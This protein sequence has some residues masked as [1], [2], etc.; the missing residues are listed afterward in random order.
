[1]TTTILV[2]SQT[3]E[4]EK[5][6]RRQRLATGMAGGNAVRNLSAEAQLLDIEQTL[7]SMIETGEKLFATSFH[8]TF[9]E[10]DENSLFL[11]ELADAERIGAGCRWFEETVGAY[12]V[13][14]GIL[15]FA[16][17]FLV[18][19][20]RVLSSVLSDLLPVYGIGAGHSNAEVLFETPYQSAIGF[21]L[22]EKSPSGNGL[23]IGSTGTGKS[24]LACGLILGMLAQNPN[25]ETKVGGAA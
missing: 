1:L 9:F 2:L 6:S 11:S 16:P 22:F 8:L 23:L 14:F 4:K 18:R 12:P 13:F 20:K 15:P 24:T 25:A 19:P 5:L 7:T 17:Q 10:K 21:S 3:E